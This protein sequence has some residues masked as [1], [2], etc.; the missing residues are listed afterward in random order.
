MKPP[1][2]PYRPRRVLARIVAVS[3]RDLAVSLGPAVLLV[4]GAIWFVMAWLQ[5]A[6]PNHLTIT[7]GPPGTRNWLA[8]EQYL[9]LIHI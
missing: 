8:A 6:P 1:Q 5:P 2:L 3:W 4:A 9:S 7:S